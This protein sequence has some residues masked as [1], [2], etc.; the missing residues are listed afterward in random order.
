MLLVALLDES[1]IW[2]T[3]G[4]EIWAKLPLASLIG[5]MLTLFRL[6]FFGAGHEWRR[7]CLFSPLPK[8]CHTDPTMI[9]LGA[10]IPYVKKIQKMYKSRD[11]SLE[12]C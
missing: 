3:F 12:F 4:P 11:T 10:V 2:E 1:Y 7:G 9:K 8:I 6:G 5:R